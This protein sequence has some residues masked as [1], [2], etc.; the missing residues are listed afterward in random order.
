MKILIANTSQIPVHLYGGTERVIWWLGKALVG[1][2]HQVSYLVKPG[3]SCPFAAEVLPLDE[4]KPIAGQI[5]DNC[6]IVHLHFPV[7]EALPKPH[8]T[9]LHGNFSKPRSFHPNSVFVSHDHAL[10]H[11]GSVFVHNGIDFDD[12]GEPDLDNARK[13]L[14]FLGKA[15]WRVKNVRGA[16]DIAGRAGE[17]IHIIGGSRVNFRMGLRITLNQHARFHGMLGGDGKNAIIN[18]SKGLVFP[19]L[20]HE[21]F[22]LAIVESLYFGCPLFGTPYGSLPELM[23]RKV[24]PEQEKNQWN[25]ALDAYY[26]DFGCLS[27]KK[28]RPRGSHPKLGKLR[29]AALPPIRG[30]SIFGSANGQGLSATLRKGA[31]RNAASRTRASVGR[32]PPLKAAVHEGVSQLAMYSSKFWIRA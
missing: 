3:S 21:P 9:I 25:G 26:S 1:M 11:G 2:G 19:V 27:Q 20:W 10:R 18:G 4:K 23:G 17:R 28:I 22:G 32:K 16:I 5:P 31:E 12:Y 7:D 6:D 13:Y 14:H 15:A 29:P 30:R 8:L 24:K